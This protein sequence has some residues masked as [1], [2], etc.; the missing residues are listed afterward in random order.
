MIGSGMNEHTTFLRLA[1]TRVDFPLNPAEAR[2]L[3][4]HIDG[5]DACHK[6]AGALRVDASALRSLLGRYPPRVHSSPT[7]GAEMVDE[8]RW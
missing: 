5:C 6:T 4:Q 2:A 3:A 7:G 8:V 1:A